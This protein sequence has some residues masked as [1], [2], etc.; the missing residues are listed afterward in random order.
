M[1]EAGPKAR[2]A[3]WVKA[4]NKSLLEREKRKKFFENERA[5]RECL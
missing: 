1:S 4:A 2:K 5:K 3:L